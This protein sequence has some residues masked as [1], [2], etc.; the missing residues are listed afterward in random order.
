MYQAFSPTILI[1]AHY[2]KNGGLNNI[3]N[4]TIFITLQ[5]YHKGVFGE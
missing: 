4:F 1:I 5:I 2:L 3:K